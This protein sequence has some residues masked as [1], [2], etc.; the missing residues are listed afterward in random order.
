MEAEKSRQ[1]LGVRQPSAAFVKLTGM[2]RHISAPLGQA[3]E[4]AL[5]NFIS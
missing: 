5:E 1:R 3:N 4:L 2:D